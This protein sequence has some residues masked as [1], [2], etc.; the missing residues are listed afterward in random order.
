MDSGTSSSVYIQWLER[1]KKTKGY[2]LCIPWYLAS[3]WRGSWTSCDIYEVRAAGRLLDIT[4][5]HFP[6]S[7]ETGVV[8]P[9]QE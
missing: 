6:A 4:E 1:E 2:D 8:R 7:P 5:P 9:R 3:E